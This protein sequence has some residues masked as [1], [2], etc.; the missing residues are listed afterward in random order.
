MYFF[1]YVLN[2]LLITHKF[3]SGIAYLGILIRDILVKAFRWT[4]IFGYF[5][6]RL[7]AICFFGFFTVFGKI[8][9]GIV[10][11]SYFGA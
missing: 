6:V 9:K 4:T 5:V 3:G 2:S 1:F 10:T 11:R 8:I 7:L